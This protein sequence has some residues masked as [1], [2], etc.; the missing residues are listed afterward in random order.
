MATKPTDN[1]VEKQQPS[2]LS[3]PILTD[4]TADINQG[5]Q[6]YMDTTNH[7]VKP[8]GASDDTNAANFCGVA[9]DGS[10]IQPYSAKVYADRIPVGTKGVFRFNT[11]VGDT[12][13]DGDALYVGADAQTVTNTV[14][15]LTKKI[16]YVKLAPGQS[17]L[18]GAAG[19][20]VEAQITPLWPVTSA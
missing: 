14:G 12:Y 19:V 4:G 8:L 10:F 1:L 3:F 16:G 7:V 5:D 17:T 6:L 15:A 2:P 9:Q 18:A 20:T 13:H 11:T